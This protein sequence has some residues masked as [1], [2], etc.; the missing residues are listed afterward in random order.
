LSSLY[1][2]LQE[3]QTEEIEMDDE[4]FLPLPVDDEDTADT[5]TRE[6]QLLQIM[7]DAP[8]FSN[9]QQDRR[10]EEVGL[11]RPF[12]SCCTVNKNRKVVTFDVTTNLC[13]GVTQSF[14]MEFIPGFPAR[15]CLLGLPLAGEGEEP[16]LMVQNGGQLPPLAVA[17]FDSW[18]NRT[19]PPEVSLMCSA[20]KCSS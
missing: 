7:A 13:P 14:T 18:N 15:L 3:L 2:A 20:E 1:T 4:S 16:Q 12:I 19:D 10:W 9:S 17:C 11:R 8:A 5:A 6:R